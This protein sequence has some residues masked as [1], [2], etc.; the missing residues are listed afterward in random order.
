MQNPLSLIRHIRWRRFACKAAT[1][2]ATEILMNAAGLDTI[3]NY[4]EFMT[5]YRSSIMEIAATVM[6]T[7]S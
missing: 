1:V 3:A 2:M 6:T 7:I 4:A 5:E